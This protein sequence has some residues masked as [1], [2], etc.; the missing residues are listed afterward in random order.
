[1]LMTTL[2]CGAMSIVMFSVYRSFRR[3]VHGLGHWAAGLLLLVCASFLFGARGTWPDAVALLGANVA[4]M[5]GI[6]LSMLGTE[7]FYEQPPSVH[8]YAL[9]CALG[10][11]GIAWW[12]LVTPDFSR[13]VTV[14]SLVVFLFYARQAQLVF[15]YGERHFSSLFFGSLMLVQAAV[16]LVRG[17]AALLHGGASVDLTVTG[18]LASVY[19]AAANFMALLLT[20]GFM[21]VATRRLY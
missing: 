15:R 13:R 20:V 7:K 18:T 12:L 4:L 2:M 5:L 10:T 9:A 8:F 6:G 21:T 11:A 1:M 16:V 3:E 14:F 17:G 19:L